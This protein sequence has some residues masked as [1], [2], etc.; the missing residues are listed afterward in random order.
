M[1]CGG[2]LSKKRFVLNRGLRHMEN[3]KSRNY[4]T[5]ITFFIAHG[6][7]AVVEHG[8]CRI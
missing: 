2:V 8:D 6:C 1:L 3:N 7:I 5:K 4:E